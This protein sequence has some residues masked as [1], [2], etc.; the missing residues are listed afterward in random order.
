[1]IELLIFVWI[2][3]LALILKEILV[4]L[5]IS[6]GENFLVRLIAV[7]LTICVAPAAAVM[8]VKYKLEEV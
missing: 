1:M 4:T 6:N 3:S 5:V 8:Q 7:C 2:I